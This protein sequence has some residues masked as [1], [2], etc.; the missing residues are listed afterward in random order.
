MENKKNK[1]NNLLGFNEYDKLDRNDLDK[2]TKRTEIGGDILKEHH[3]HTAEDQK[4]YILTN[5]DFISDDLVKTIYD[6]M[7]NELLEDADID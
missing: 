6:L 2:S 4:E 3:M 7:E 5:L 1:L